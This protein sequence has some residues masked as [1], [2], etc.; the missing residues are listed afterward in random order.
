MYA[1]RIRGRG[2]VTHVNGEPL[3][4]REQAETGRPDVPGDGPA[5]ATAAAL[6]HAQ[7]LRLAMYVPPR[8]WTPTHRALGLRAAFEERYLRDTNL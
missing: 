4:T 3:T 2:L 8:Y 7:R 5:R 6:R 1:I